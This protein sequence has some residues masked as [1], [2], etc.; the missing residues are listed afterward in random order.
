MKSGIFGAV[1]LLALAGP[2]WAQTTI[3]NVNQT[4]DVISG[5]AVSSSSESNNNR[6]TSQSQ[7]QTEDNRESGDVN[8]TQGGTTATVGPTP[9]GGVL[10]LPG[11][12]VATGAVASPQIATNHTKVASNNGNTQS[13]TA[14]N[15]DH[16][17]FSDNHADDSTTTVISRSFN[18][19][20]GSFNGASLAFGRSNT[21][22]AG[23][24]TFDLD[25]KVVQ[26]GRLPTTGLMNHALALL[27]AAVFL[28]A[29]GLYME[30]TG[31]KYA[32]NLKSFAL[33]RRRLRPALRMAL[34]SFSFI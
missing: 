16:S 10:T 14:T 24:S 15:D 22:L 1:L 29:F 26:G 34:V 27:T 5:P 17:T 21:A 11:A 31:W 6:T 23:I 32:E 4:A 18:G 13:Q 9:V 19:N 2:A 20:T 30:F 3:N 25:R 7:S 12:A 33:I 8:Q 28:V